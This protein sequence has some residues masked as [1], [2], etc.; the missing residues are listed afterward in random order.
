MDII[1]SFHVCSYK[2]VVSRLNEDFLSFFHRIQQLCILGLFIEDVIFPLS[3]QPFRSCPNFDHVSFSEFSQLL[4]EHCFM[5]ASSHIIL[6]LFL[7]SLQL[8]YDLFVPLFNCLVCICLSRRHVSKYLSFCSLC[9]FESLYRDIVVISQT[10]S[11]HPF[12]FFSPS[13][14]IIGMLN[15]GRSYLLYSFIDRSILPRQ[16]S[17]TVFSEHLLR[18][19]TFLKFILVP[20]KFWI[21][22][23]VFC[24]GLSLFKLFDS[25]LFA[26]LFFDSC[27]NF[28]QSLCIYPSNLLVSIDGILLNLLVSFQLILPFLFLLLLLK[29][30]HCVHLLLM[31]VMH[32]FNS[33]LLLEFV[34]VQNFIKSFFLFFIFNLSFKLIINFPSCSGLLNSSDSCRLTMSM[35]DQLFN[36]HLS[37]EEIKTHHITTWTRR[38]LWL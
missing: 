33:L 27:F 28:C 2:V 7:T 8:E 30:C 35:G 19:C 14:D 31:G 24:W 18:C 22:S 6:N 21:D 20:F 17:N 26:L 4:F 12:L 36:R 38:V 11:I 34:W 25:F 3:F 37:D 23:L 9:F 10:H 15:R 13:Y 29:G 32:I 16:N 5:V 1:V